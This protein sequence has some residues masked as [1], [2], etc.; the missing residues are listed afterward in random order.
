MSLVPHG[1]RIRPPF[2]SQLPAQTTHFRPPYPIH[3]QNS[4]FLQASAPVVISQT[5]NAVSTKFIN[6]LGRE[7]EMVR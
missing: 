6:F 7:R 5:F 3:A 1:Y 4:G 2:Y